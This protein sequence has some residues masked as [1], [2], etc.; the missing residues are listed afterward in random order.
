[1]LKDPD[2]QTRLAAILAL[3]DVPSSA[4]IGRALYAESQVSPN[5]SDKWLSRALYIA[6]MRHQ[7]GFTAAYHADRNR[8]PYTAL[9]VALRLGSIK[10]DWRTPPA[11]EL[12]GE[13]K[14]MQV[15]GNWESR[16]LPDFDGVVWFTRTVDWP[17]GPAPAGLTLGSVRN[18]AE[19]W[20]NGVSVTAAPFVPP[21]AAAAPG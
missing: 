1:M 2:L 12:A 9:P 14:A 6:A 11:P 20:V 5:F 17:A 19:V 8:L 10:P 16:G 21:A 13:W 7:A 15:P 3:A 4:E 18:S